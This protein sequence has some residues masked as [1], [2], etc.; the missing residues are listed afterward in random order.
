M[1]SIST[2]GSLLSTFSVQRK[3]N[4]QKITLVILIE[5]KHVYNNNNCKKIRTC[6]F[7]LMLLL[8][9][10]FTYLYF[11][12]ST[13]CESFATSGHCWYFTLSLLI[14]GQN[15]YVS[16]E[17]SGRAAGTAAIFLVFRPAAWRHI[18]R[19]FPLRARA[20]Y[21]SIPPL[22]KQVRPARSL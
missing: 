12:L 19:M 10:F 3:T 15:V 20:H 16:P 17:V 8:D 9:Y 14:T 4:M 18:A 13:E 11:N 21:D 22:R 6:T 5:C 7:I 2:L 1:K